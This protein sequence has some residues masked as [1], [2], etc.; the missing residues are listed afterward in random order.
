[1]IIDDSEAAALLEELKAKVRQ[2][3]DI[4]RMQ[5]AQSENISP[6]SAAER[7]GKLVRAGVLVDAGRVWDPDKR[8]WMHCWRRKSVK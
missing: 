6:S 4:D 8:A 5:Y 1:M 3:G 7:L 2:R